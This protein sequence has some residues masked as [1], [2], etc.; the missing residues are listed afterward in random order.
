MKVASAPSTEALAW[1]VGSI[2]DDQG[3]FE[4][5]GVPDGPVRLVFIAVGYER[6][7][8]IDDLTPG[9]DSTAPTTSGR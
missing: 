7:E 8:Y 3:R 2:T 9:G 4:L 6:L 5:R 1:E